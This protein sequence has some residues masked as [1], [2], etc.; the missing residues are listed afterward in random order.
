MMKHKICLFDVT[1][2]HYRKEIFTLM[3]KTFDVD[4]YFG[5]MMPS[6]KQ[7]NKEAL[8]G[9]KRT[10]HVRHIGPFFWYEGMVRTVLKEYDTLIFDGDYRCLS[11][12][13][14]LLLCKIL[15]KKTYL[16]THGFYGSESGLKKILKKTDGSKCTRMKYLRIIVIRFMWMEMLFL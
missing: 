16:W 6:I 4:F 15:K 5:D 10:L 13:V 11:T 14:S 3:D 1:A 8:K 12:W 2:S 9:Y 7:M